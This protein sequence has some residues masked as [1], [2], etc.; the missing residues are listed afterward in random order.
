MAAKALAVEIN[1]LAMLFNDPDPYGLLATHRKHFKKPGVWE[2]LLLG[3]TGREELLEI[4]HKKTASSKNK[5]TR[6]EF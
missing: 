5:N 1:D 4:H 3:K 6:D 2:S